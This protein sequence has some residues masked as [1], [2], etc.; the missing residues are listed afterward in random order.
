MFA[1][2]EDKSEAEELQSD[3][4]LA[5]EALEC[6]RKSFELAG[7]ESNLSY[8]SS[9]ISC[10]VSCDISRSDVHIA[11][12]DVASES[13]NFETA[14][15]EYTKAISYLDRLCEKEKDKEDGCEGFHRRYGEVFFKSCR[16][17]EFLENPEEAAKYCDKAIESIRLELAIKQ[18]TEEETGLKE[19]EKDLVERRNVIEISI[20]EYD[21]VKH[22]LRQMFEQNATPEPKEKELPAVNLGIVGR[23]KRRLQ[24]TPIQ[25]EDEAVDGDGDSNSPLQKRAASLDGEDE[26]SRSN[27]KIRIEETTEPKDET[28]PKL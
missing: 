11:L 9:K 10:F 26:K 22:S 24:M 13:S 14:F 7:I 6:A 15:D 8:L 2:T 4:S 27:K 18:G 1:E 20:R 21:Q 28:S 12:G 19:I 23:G 3:L 16:T 25:E 5:W 17:Q